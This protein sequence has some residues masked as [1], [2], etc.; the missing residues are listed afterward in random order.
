[1]YCTR[2]EEQ[3]AHTMYFAYVWPTTLLFA[4]TVA[5]GVVLSHLTRWA[6]RPLSLIEKIVLVSAV[7]SA[8]FSLP[9]WF[10]GNNYVFGIVISWAAFFTLLAVGSGLRKPV[11]LAAFVNLVVF[12]YIVN[13]FRGNNLL[14]LQSSN[15]DSDN[16]IEAIFQ[17]HHLDNVQGVDTVGSVSSA[18]YHRST[19]RIVNF[20]S[21]LVGGPSDRVVDAYNGYF[22]L[23]PRLLDFRTWNP[24]EMYFGYATRGWTIAVGVFILISFIALFLQVILLVI[25]YFIHAHGDAQKAEVES[26]LS[27]AFEE[28]A[29]DVLGAD[30]TSTGFR[31]MDGAPLAARDEVDHLI[32]ARKP[33]T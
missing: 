1:M 30:P 27:P 25:A 26:A 7:V 32:A 33:L 24:Y 4:F 9:T 28:P 29:E 22:Q 8:L 3:N 12:L 10:H 6:M 18:T 19:Q 11:L 20:Q 15:S 5:A 17:T 23:D 13:P 2:L 21:T 16:M 31:E 14:N